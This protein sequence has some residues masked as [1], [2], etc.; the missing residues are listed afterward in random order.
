MNWFLAD[1]SIDLIASFNKMR[2]LT[3]DRNL[4]VSAME[5]S[6]LLQVYP[7]YSMMDMILDL[8]SRSL[9]TKT[10]YVG[11]VHC[12]LPQKMRSLPELSTW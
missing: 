11:S 2:S 4:I 1:V 3:T 10:W 9:S 7:S 8:L 12:I 6:S 5:R